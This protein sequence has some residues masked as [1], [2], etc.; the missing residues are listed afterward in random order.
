MRECVERKA[1]GKG[2]RERE[3]EIY[4]LSSIEF[5][6]R[7]YEHLPLYVCVGGDGGRDAGPLHAFH[8]SHLPR[9]RE[10]G[11]SFHQ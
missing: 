5:R 9:Y 6:V 1:E 2:E 4:E 10:S 11:F 7:K 3:K 8:N